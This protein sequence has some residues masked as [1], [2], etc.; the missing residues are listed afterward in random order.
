MPTQPVLSRRR[1]LAALALSATGLAG[2]CQAKQGSNGGQAAPSSSTSAIPGPVTSGTNGTAPAGAPPPLFEPARGEVQVQAKRVAG[3][4]V[5]QLTTYGPETSPG[6]VAADL[7]G[8]GRNPGEL[9]KAAG[10]LLVPGATSV[11]EVV[12]GQLGGLTASAAAVM[13]VLRQRLSNENGQSATTTRTLDVRLRR[14]GGRWVLDQLASVGGRPA[15]R[16]P[17]LSQAARAVL[18]N[19]RIQLPDSARWDIHRGLVEERLLQLMQAVATHQP[20]AVTVLVSGHPRNVFGTN[21]R[22][23]HNVGRAVDLYLVAG[24]PV[25]GQRGRGSA[26]Y[27]LAGWL[28]RAGP[29]EL[30]S[31]WRFAGGGARSFTNTVHQDHI[32]IGFDR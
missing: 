26:A 6:S 32:H 17:D 18:D 13:V 9:V 10:P 27:R 3:R 25:V 12:Y 24:H 28:D 11:G 2:A 21:R 23:N 1:L 15:A 20:Y 30:G 4:A 29:T 19:P 7:L 31:P 16:P 22:S 8:P 14:T 5:Q